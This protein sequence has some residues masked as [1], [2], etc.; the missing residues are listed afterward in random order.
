MATFKKVVPVVQ[1]LTC[2]R[3][4]DILNQR[5][6]TLTYNL[7]RSCKVKPMCST[8][9]LR[10]VQHLKCCRSWHFTSKSMTL[11]FDP[12]GSCKVKSDGAN[13]KPVGPTY[14]CSPG[15]NL[16]SVTVFEIFWVKGLWPWPLTS[17]GHPKYSPWAV[18]IISVESHI[19]T[20]AVRDIFHVTKYNLEVWPF[21]V[22]Q[23]QIWRCQSKTRGSYDQ[24]LPGGPAS[25]L[26]PFS[27]YFK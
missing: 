20:V 21:K 3:F 27:R 23:G 24:V 19:V 13:R 1:P 16:A 15:S 25:S 4:R 9:K 7:S 6:V 14:K 22:L 2:H 11:I 26:S 8:Y 12:W 17:Q 18:S 10:W 5:I